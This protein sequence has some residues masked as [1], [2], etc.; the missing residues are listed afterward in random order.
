MTDLN[1]APVATFDRATSIYT[2]QERR[3]LAFARVMDLFGYILLLVNLYDDA[4]SGLFR[5]ILSHVGATW[6][7]YIPSAAVFPFCGAYLFGRSISN[8]GAILA[9]GAFLG[10]SAL[11]LMSLVLGRSAAEATFAAYTLYP[12]LVAFPYV[13]GSRRRSIM[14]HLIT[15]WLVAVAGVFLNKFY[16]LPW[17]GDS[18]EVLG[19]TVDSSRL[20]SAY[21]ISRLAGFTRGSFAVGSQILITSCFIISAPAEVR[22]KFFK[23]IIFLARITVWCVSLLAIYLTTYKTA[24]F[25]EFIIPLIPLGYVV[26]SDGFPRGNLARISVLRGYCEVVIGALLLLI[27]AL[28]VGVEAYYFRP[29]EAVRGGFITTASLFDRAMNTW[30][31]VWRLI[32][33]DNNQAE[34]VLGRGLGGVGAS[35]Y[36]LDPA[37]ANPADNLFMYVYCSVGLGFAALWWL[38]TRATASRVVTQS[39]ADARVLLT[40]LCGALILGITG[41]VLESVFPCFAIGLAL[42]MGFSS[43]RADV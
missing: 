43:T 35:Q 5:Y 19:Q 33:S 22:A 37:H 21:S 31:G 16:A 32:A 6:L 9:L 12:L 42:A 18:Y 3:A 23:V 36:L 27:A 40:V 7:I 28:P 8:R 4:F 10:L 14:P 29:T 38:L 26:L 2:P 34:W 17:I 39:I 15:I 41:T 24:L 30:P 13:A 11:L 25:A 1:R 20:W